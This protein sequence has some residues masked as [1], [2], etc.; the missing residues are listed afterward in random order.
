M[1]TVENG[2]EPRD[3]CWRLHIKTSAEEG[4]DPHNFCITTGILG[5]GWS[6]ETDEESL[7]WERYR[8]LGNELYHDDNGWWPAV[9]ALYERMHVNELCWTRNSDGLYHL[10]RI[11]SEWS[12]QNTLEN[13]QADAVNVRQCEWYLVGT[14]DS[15]PGKI[16]NAFIPSATVQKVDDKSASAYSHYLFN[17]L[18]GRSFCNLEQMCND[19]DLLSL[20]SAEDCEDIVGIYLQCQGYRLIPS[21]CRSD[22]AGYEFVLKRKGSG[23]SAVVQVKQGGPPLDASEYSEIFQE[24]KVFLFHTQG[25]YTGNR[26]SNVECLDPEEMKQFALSNRKIMSDRLNIWID[27]WQEMTD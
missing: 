16:V 1:T 27:I 20:V 22:T 21:S 23:E 26:Q 10:G 24:E 19:V 13:R 8:D 15:V 4:I 9:R 17:R 3:F 7:D 11:T 18:C 12:Y 5:V 14:V 2:I 6:V 25:N